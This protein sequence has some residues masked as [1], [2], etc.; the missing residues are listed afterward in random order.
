MKKKMIAGLVSGLMLA[1][2]AAGWKG[3]E[4]ANYYSGP[5]LTE[6]DLAGKVVL[7]DCWGVNCGPC[8]QLLPSMEKI[9]NSFKSKPFVL[10][11]AHWQG[12]QPEKVAE[13]VKANKLTYPIYDRAGVANEPK[14]AGLPF[15]Y[16]VDHRG[17]IVFQGDGVKGTDREAIEAIVN[18]LGE[19][20]APPTLIPGVILG[21]KSAH[22]SLE[23]QLILGKPAANIVK[24]LQAEIK[25]AEKKTATAIQKKNAEEAEQMLQAIETAKTD[26]KTDIAQ[27]KLSNPPEALKM[28]KAYMVSFPEEG[29]AYKDEL[30]DLTAKAK[31]FA[32]EAKAKGAKK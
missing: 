15:F 31:E 12:R 4:E 26:Y 1:V 8:K 25:A 18:A 19:I 32:A 16:V 5:K 3:L 23:K 20:G 7:V 14:F 30:A 11:G 13:L 29:A 22:K 27:L 17:K 21:K 2:Q 28:V 6:A 9:W 10:I 24:K